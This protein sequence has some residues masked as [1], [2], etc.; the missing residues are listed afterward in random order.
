MGNFALASTDL[1]ESLKPIALDQ[2]IAVL[3]ILRGIALLGNLI[4]NMRMFSLP[5]ASFFLNQPY[6]PEPWNQG[7]LEWVW[8]VGTYGSLTFDRDRKASSLVPA[9]TEA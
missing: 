4:I 5:S 7:P 9:S 1:G 6:F 3:D 8:K 2:R